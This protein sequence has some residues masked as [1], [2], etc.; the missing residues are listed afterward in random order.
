M[1]EPMPRSMIAAARSATAPTKLAPRRTLSTIMR[2]KL[3]RILIPDVR[4]AGSAQ[5]RTAT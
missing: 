2:P 3:M 1:L 5:Q 4:L